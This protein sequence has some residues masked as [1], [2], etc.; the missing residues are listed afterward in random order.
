MDKLI[1]MP[2]GCGEQNML[3]FVPN[4]VVLDYL[5]NVKQLTSKTKEKLLKH[6]ESGYQRELTYKH[7]DGSYSAFGPS[8]KKGSTWLTA[9]VAKSFKHASKYMNIEENIIDQTLNWLVSKQNDDGSFSEVGKILSQSMQGGSGKGVALTAYTL[10][11]LLEHNKMKEKYGGSIEKAL[12]YVADKS[13]DLNDTYSLAI[14][15]YAMQLANHNSKDMLLVKLD[16]KATSND[17]MKFWRK[18]DSENSEKSI[19]IDIEMTAY[20]M[21]AYIEAGFETQAVPI[22]KWLISQRNENGGFQST[23]DTVVGLQALSKLAEKIYVPES[24]I[25]ILVENFEKLEAKMN[26]NKE[27]ALVLQKHQLP[28]FARDITLKARGN[29]VAMIQVSYKFNMDI[30]ETEPK[31][32]IDLENKKKDNPNLMELEVCSKYVADSYSKKSNMAVMEISLPSGFTYDADS[33][34]EILKTDKI[35]VCI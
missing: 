30:P 24:N 13:Q 27:N 20:A 29:G 35:K 5:T 1:K 22:M 11:A 12:K 21:L 2:H 33:T 6:M 32:M 17:G 10:I 3:N 16:S 18:S 15:A 8:D 23:Q 34:A 4:I 25:E 14:A 31:F 26:V 7:P 9:F 28:P 19:S